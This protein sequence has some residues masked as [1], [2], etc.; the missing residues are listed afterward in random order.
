M[1]AWILVAAVTMAACVWGTEVTPAYTVVAGDTVSQVFIYSPGERDGL[2]LAYLAEDGGWQHVGQLCGSDYGPWGS[3]KRMHR[4]SVA[5]AADGTWR[6]VF[7]V[8]DYAPCLAVAYS[9]DLVTWRPQDYPR[10]SSAGCLDPVVFAMDDGTTDIY[11]KDRA[12]GKHYV[13]ASADFRHFTEDKVLSTIDD[14]AWLRDTCEVRSVEGE[15]KTMEG[16]IFDIP[17]LHLKYVRQWFRALAED[18]HRSSEAMR[19]DAE[20]FAGLPATLEARVEVNVGEEKAI[21]D[22]LV[23]VFFEDI[24]YAADGGL[25]AE[26]VQNRDFEYSSR[27]RREWNALTAWTTSAGVKLTTDEPLSQ[28]NPH[29]V[30]MDADTL[31]NS[32]WDGIMDAGGRYDFSCYIRLV[33]C[34]KKLFT[35]ALVADDGTVMAE[36]R[37]KAEGE[38]WRRYE[39]VLDTD[40]KQKRQQA[41]TIEPQDVKRCQLRIVGKKGGKAALDMISLFPQDTYKGHGLRW[42]LAEAIAALKP[43]FVRFPG[44]CM[45]HGQGLENI[46]HWN[47]TVGPWQ[48]RK[49]DLNIW[50]YH[51]TRGLGFYEYFQFC[52]DIGAEPLPVLAAGVPCQNSAADKGGYAGQQGG[53]P[54]EDMP[55]YIDE[56][57]NLIEWANGDAA[58]SQWARLRAEA[59]HPEPFHLKYI[60]IGNEDLISTAFEERYEMICRAIR[61]RYPDITICGTVG[62]FHDPSSDYIEGWRFANDHRDI[63]DMVDEHYY[64]SPGWFIAHQ[65]YYDD[66]DRTGPKVYVG[67][68]ASRTRTHESALAEALYL[69]NIERNADIVAMTSYAP[70]LAKNGHHNWNPDMIYFDNTSLQLTPSYYTQWLFGNHSGDR[71]VSSKFKVQGPALTEDE[72]VGRRSAVSVVRDSKTGRTYLKLV[73]ALPRELKVTVEGLALPTDARVSAFT[74]NP[75]DKTVTLYNADDAHLSGERCVTVSGQQVSLQPY[76]VCA[77]EL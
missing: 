42:D 26:L 12:G 75:T 11:Y 7:S 54:M 27:D 9:E 43:K 48:D 39:L 45:S 51:Q 49:P 60:G 1:R 14:V 3:E 10:L 77:I 25:Y 31:L 64:E 76:T 19:D 41:A 73:N 15:A 20:R 57:C 72:N 5:H 29:H 37:L 61:Q 30:V 16:Y 36:G 6:L 74:A 53:I 58:T 44:G 59:G 70:L 62:P 68:Y 32:G 24:S 66:Y 71:Y 21:S 38:G 40:K 47:E 18:A 8:N 34:R 50:H 65:D 69:C 2:H 67:E 33:D 28:N 52:E 55:A 4:P 17:A 23:G 35:V 63:I 22:N 46:Y 13:Q 56:L